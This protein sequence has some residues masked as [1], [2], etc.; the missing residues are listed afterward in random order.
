VSEP[1]LSGT[2][3]LAEHTRLSLTPPLPSQLDFHISL[4]PEPTFEFAAGIESLREVGRAKVEL[5]AV[6]ES[7][8]ERTVVYREVFRPFQLNH[9]HPRRVDLTAWSGET[10]TLRLQVRPAFTNPHPPWADRIRIAWGDPTISIG[11][12]E[13]WIQRGMELAARLLPSPNRGLSRPSIVLVLVDTLRADYLGSYGFEGDVSPGLDRLAAESLR[14]TSC[15][16]QAPWSKP[17]ITTL[18]TSLYPEVHGLTDHEGFFRSKRQQ[19]MKTGV[20]PEEAVT[21]AELL[22]EGGYR[23]AGFITNPLL[24]PTYGFDQGFDLYEMHEVQDLS[25]PVMERAKRWIDSQP[26]GEP[27]FAYLHFM[28]VHGPYQSPEEDYDAMKGSA[29]LGNP[30]QLTDQEYDAISDYLKRIP[31]A[32][33]P[34]AR[35]LTTW[36]ARYAAGIRDFDRRFSSFVD[37]LRTSGRLDD[38]Y[39]VVT[40]DH[41]EEFLEHGGWDH[42]HTLFVE[43]LHVPLLVRKPGGEGAREVQNIV[44]LI[45]L[46]PTLASIAGI[47]SPSPLQGRD[48]SALLDGDTQVGL[49]TSLATAT[50]D[51]PG[52]HAIRTRDHKVIVD[53]DSG[54]TWLFDTQT[55]PGEEH[56]LASRE[57]AIADDLR[58]RLLAHIAGST[59]QEILEKRLAPIPDDLIEQLRSLGYVQ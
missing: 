39:L 29:S 35:E 25:Q 33:R 27:F 59:A 43:Q 24:A 57:P 51:H 19:K 28:D 55:D 47:Y 12:R 17:S 54:E 45:D 31:W 2:V 40:S 52:L 1:S 9:W 3:T 23:T 42:G 4:P 20:L 34:P 48:V 5:Q 53:L 44:N 37:E 7:R 11:S 56:N 14:F 30:R 58:Q 13:S 36:R 50:S 18:F 49:E 41:G 46:M 26:P 22:R 38:T 10:V 15:F 32:R 21:L 16:S 8:G 6:V